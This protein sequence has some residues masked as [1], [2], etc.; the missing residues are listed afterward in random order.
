M[1]KRT[2]SAVPAWARARSKSCRA[3]ANSRGT[4]DRHR[5]LAEP[6]CGSDRARPGGRWSGGPG[7][8]SRQRGRPEARQVAADRPRRGRRPSR[9]RRPP[10]PPG[11][12]RSARRV[13]SSGADPPASSN[14]PRNAAVTGPPAAGCASGCA[15]RAIARAPRGRL[16]RSPRC[17]AVSS[18]SRLAIAGFGDIERSPDDDAMASV[19]LPT[20]EDRDNGGAGAKREQGDGAGR[21]GQAPKKGDEDA[22]GA[23]GVLVQQ[24]ADHASAR[25]RAEDRAQG[26]ALVDQ[27]GPVR[28]RKRSARGLSR[29]RRGAG[30]PRPTDKGSLGVPR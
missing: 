26:P 14:K 3:R 10:P 1:V 21:A 7:S 5:F 4:S 13:P 2:R 18:H 16:L 11:R 25:Q 20:R 15:P 28:S 8:R 23:G 9:R 17:G 22:L 24:D 12:P 30:P 19:P 29:R 27:L 6:A